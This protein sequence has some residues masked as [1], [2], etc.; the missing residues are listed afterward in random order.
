MA[1]TLTPYKECITLL[2]THIEY[3]L[4]ETTDNI[5]LGYW[6]GFFITKL[7][8]ISNNWKKSLL[9]VNSIY[10]HILIYV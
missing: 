8:V 10:I 3:Y 2:I 7:V 9:T 4:R 1:S 6:L 5:L